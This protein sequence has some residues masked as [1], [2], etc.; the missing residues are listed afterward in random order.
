MVRGRVESGRTDLND[1]EDAE[2]L[3]ELAVRH[4]EAGRK[5]EARR[6]LGILRFRYGDTPSAA[7]ATIARIVKAMR[8]GKVED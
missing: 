1:E 2:V 5:D 3:A 7:P 6:A 4:A 8:A